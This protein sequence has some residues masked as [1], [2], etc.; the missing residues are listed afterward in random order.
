MAAAVFQHVFKVMDTAEAVVAKEAVV[1]RAE[2]VAMEE[3]DLSGFGLIVLILV[4]L[5]KVLIYLWGHLD[6]AATAELEAMEETA[7]LEVMVL[8]IVPVKEVMQETAELEAMD[9]GVVAFQMEKTASMHLLLSMEPHQIHQLQFPT[10]LRLQ[11]TITAREIIFLEK[12]V[13]IQ[14]LISRKH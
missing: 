9:Q 2:Q 14:K 4:F 7:E 3:E 12:F 6:L 5:F 1:A 11:S 8:V 13:T 10:Y